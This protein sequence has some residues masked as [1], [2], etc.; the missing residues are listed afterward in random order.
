MAGEGPARQRPVSFG[1]AGGAALGSERWVPAGYG[2]VRQVGYGSARRGM[3]RCDAVWSGL[4]R[5]SKAGRV[6]LGFVRCGIVR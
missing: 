6:R 2:V 1:K 4:F 3:V 5:L